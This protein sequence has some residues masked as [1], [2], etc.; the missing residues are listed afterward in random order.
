MS[1]I[2]CRSNLLRGSLQRS[3]SRRSDCCYTYIG[4]SNCA[5]K[6]TEQFTRCGEPLPVV[7]HV[8]MVQGRME[9][10]P[11]GTSWI[12]SGHVRNTRYVSREQFHSWGFDPYSRPICA[13][14]IPIRRSPEWRQLANRTRREIILSQSH[15]AVRGLQSLSAILRAWRHRC[16][17]S[18]QFD[19]VTWFEYELQDAAAFDDLLADWRASEEWKYVDRECDIRLIRAC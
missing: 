18:E 19:D 10:M 17:L 4:G 11:A 9:S 6:V 14:L 15:A 1:V 3:S 7:S 5:W 2:T 8:E 16:D 13:A 12:L